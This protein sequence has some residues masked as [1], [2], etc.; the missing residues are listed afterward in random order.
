MLEAV[1][2][3]KKIAIMHI[4]AHQKA[5]LESEKG[6][7]LADREAKEAAK[8]EVQLEGALIPDRKISLE[9]KPN[10]DK[11]DLK[12]ITN[13]DETYSKEG[14]APTPEGR[15]IIPG[16]LIWF[17]I[18]EEHRKRHWGPETVYEHLNHNIMA[19]N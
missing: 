17:V 18:R 10:Y 4:R 11:E 19:R 8:R 15:V 3:P 7:E 1:Q 2:L 6:N 9:G 5:Y 14:W 16:H 12:L 13:L